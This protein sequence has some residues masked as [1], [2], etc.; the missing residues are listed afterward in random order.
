MTDDEPTEEDWMWVG[1]DLRVALNTLHRV[2]GIPEIPYMTKPCGFP[3][4]ETLAE[5]DRI[6]PG[7]SD[8]FRNQARSQMNH[9]KQMET[10]R[11]ALLR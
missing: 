8:L 9:R 5:Y 6:V 7:S 4:D 2:M 11:S 3:S 10:M 1:N